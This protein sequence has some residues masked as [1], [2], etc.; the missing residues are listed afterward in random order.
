MSVYAYAQLV[1]GDTPECTAEQVECRV[2][3]AAG[4]V[5]A[6]NPQRGA[7]S[8]WTAFAGAFAVDGMRA[9]HV[10]T[11]R[12]AFLGTGSDIRN[13]DALSAM[14][15]LPET[16][17]REGGPCAA[18]QLVIEIAPYASAS[19][20]VLLGECAD[21]EQARRLHASYVDLDAVADARAAVDRFW[22][23]SLGALT[24]RT[25]S[26]AIDT[27]LN[28]WLLYQALSCRLWGRT[29]FY[30]SGGAFGFRDQLQDATAF[31]LTDP[32][33]VRAQILL[34][35]AHQFEAG[36]VLHW[37]HPPSERGLRTK[38]ADDLLWLPYVTAQYLHATDDRRLLDEPA[39]FVVAR[40]LADD[41]DEVFL[42]TTPS[43]TAASVWE[44][45][46]LALERSL[47]CGAHGLPLMGTGDWND[48]MNR[49]G[50]LGRGESVWLGFFLYAILEDF[51]A[52]AAT[53]GEANRAAR[54]RQYRHE[55]AAALEAA[56]WDGA[57]YRR[58]YYDDGTAI[59][60][61]AS[62]E[63]RIDGLA[64]AWSVLSRAAP[65]DRAWR[66]IESAAQQLVDEAAGMIR[67]LTPPFDQTPHDPG[68]IKGYVPGIREN[69][70]QYTHAAAWVV[71][72]A[73]ELGQRA[74]AARWF[75]M[76]TPIQ[77][78]TSAAA[79][80]L[81]KVEPYVVAADVYGVDPHVGRGGWT[82]YTGS[83]AWMYRVGVESILG[84]TVADGRLRVR[85][86]IP[87]EWRGFSIRYRRPDARTVYAI[88]VVNAD[89]CSARVIRV[90]CDQVEH[91]PVAGF[92]DVALVDD[93]N[94]HTLRVELGDAS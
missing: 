43:G 2:E 35:A 13:P 45:C 81:Y 86:C 94:E 1:L 77:H 7:F 21:D 5:L 24:V 68:Y 27:M 48:G 88:E 32:N 90:V 42:Q 53:R 67:L 89:K 4:L 31:L 46:C 58:A 26:P 54:W 44:H 18:F 91:E 65:A 47:T 92:C 87:D 52:L 76:L 17:A 39:G 12:S 29:A 6:R 23:H 55:L 84:L 57:W 70:G 15:R 9:R 83:A 8:D 78:T 80:A 11:D 19:C 63:C 28:G 69:G 85:P 34:H 66:A 37:W 20:V 93:G 74:R 73:A 61:A 22:E 3:S 10:A 71:R 59:G 50:R 41:E 25:P 75:A 51:I 40:A 82:W 16:T 72:A 33:R 14:E 38:F 30:Q 62:D 56:G 60:S 49:V 64:Q 36:D 79:V